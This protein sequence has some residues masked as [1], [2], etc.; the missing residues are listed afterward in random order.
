[1]ENENWLY[2]K[3][4]KVRPSLHT[5]SPSEL[6]VLEKKSEGVPAFVSIPAELAALKPEDLIYIKPI[7]TVAA[8]FGGEMIFKKLEGFNR[9]PCLFCRTQDGGG[10]YISLEMLVNPAN[11]RLLPLKDNPDGK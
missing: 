10:G 5:V 11:P 9:G 2:D 8:R 7:Y 3:N 4:G 1:M 6:D